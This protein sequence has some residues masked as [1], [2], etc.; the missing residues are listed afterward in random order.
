MEIPFETFAEFLG[1]LFGPTIGGFG[2]LVWFASWALEDFKFWQNLSS[3]IRSLVFYVG[4]IL[5]GIGAYLLSQNKELVAAISPYFNIILS[6]TAV[7][8]SSQVVHKVD[9]LIDKTEPEQPIEPLG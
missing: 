3:K 8:L 6:A 7:W 5:I 4:S 9:K 1:W 2:I